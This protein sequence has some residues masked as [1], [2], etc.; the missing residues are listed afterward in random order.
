MSM[1]ELPTVFDVYKESLK[2]DDHRLLPSGKSRMTVVYTKD[3]GDGSAS[4]LP[5][6]A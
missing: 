5:C 3:V 1:A 2:V 6:S 4:S